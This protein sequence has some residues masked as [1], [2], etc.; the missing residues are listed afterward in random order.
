MEEEPADRAE[1]GSQPAGRGAGHVAPPVASSGLDLGH[2]LSLSPRPP[3]MTLR[4]PR[5]WRSV[6]GA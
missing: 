2:F 4:P 5:L 3:E 1:S 6:T